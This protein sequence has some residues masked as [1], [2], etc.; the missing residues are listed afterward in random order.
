MGS[1]QRELGAGSMQLMH[2]Y[3]P[4]AAGLLALLV[5]LCEPLGLRTGAPGTV[6]HFFRCGPARFLHTEGAHGVRARRTGSA[7]LP[8]QCAHIFTEG[9]P[10][11]CLWPG[12]CTECIS[13]GAAF[14]LP[15]IR[16][17]RGALIQIRV[18]AVCTS[19][20]RSSA[21]TQT[22]S[23]SASA[24]Y[25]FLCSF[26]RQPPA[27]CQ[28]CRAMAKATEMR[29]LGEACREAEPPCAAARAEMTLAAAAAIAGSAALGL[30]V[31][32]SMFLMIGATSGVTFNVV[33]HVKTVLILAGGVM[34]FGDR[35][36]ATARPRRCSLSLR[37]G[38]L[39]AMQARQEQGAI[40][41]R[42][43]R[44][45]PVACWQAGTMSLCMPSLCASPAAWTPTCPDPRMPSP[46]SWRRAKAACRGPLGPA[47]PGG[48][49]LSG[50][51]RPAASA[52]P[53]G[54]ALVSGHARPA[55]SA[56]LPPRPHTASPNPQ[57]AHMRTCQRPPSMLARQEACADSGR[58]GPGRP[59]V[60]AAGVALAIAGIAWHS[61]LGVRAK[62][63]SAEAA[64]AAAAAVASPPE[65]DAAAGAEAKPLLPSPGKGASLRVHSSP[66]A[67]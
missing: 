8:M 15:R 2:A 56:G 57:T 59:P 11:M 7:A 22:A 26:R 21:V 35:M 52:G 48:A 41:G 51:G 42:T 32:L 17:D 10:C 33:G 18:W 47:Q 25:A 23:L 27:S 29:S 30:L 34:L 62:M 43:A 54:A 45:V 37:Q 36:C 12:A 4:Y 16:A 14:D 63:A 24:L 20:Q 66:A 13:R 1:K 58:A 38:P 5:P 50:H 55:A 60:K 53:A 3:A 64:A 19:C 65:S 6:L 67:A 40:G 28:P 46:V 61:W 49:P 31:S 39:C 44:T 9:P